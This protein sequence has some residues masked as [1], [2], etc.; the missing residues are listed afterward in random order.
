MSGNTN[1]NFLSELSIP[2]LV[3]KLH[4]AIK[5]FTESLNTLIDHN[6][7]VNYKQ[8]NELRNTIKKRIK[9]GE[10]IEDNTK[11][12]NLLELFSTNKLAIELIRED[13]DEWLDFIETIEKSINDSKIN[14]NDKEID[15]FNKIK[16]INA[17]LKDML[18]ASKK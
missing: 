9:S 16:K 5:A 2:E 18:R 10:N 7:T 12:L 11:I 13:V 8:I 3:S 6:K 15:E 17:E 1:T 4:S 14:L